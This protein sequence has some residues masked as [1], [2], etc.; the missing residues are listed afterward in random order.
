MMPTASYQ[1]D[2]QPHLDA[3]NH[4]AAADAVMAHVGNYA[5]TRPSENAQGRDSGIGTHWG[6]RRHTQR[7]NGPTITGADTFSG[8]TAGRDIDGDR[9]D[10]MLPVLLRGVVHHDAIDA[11]PPASRAVFDH[12]IEGEVPLRT[13]ANINL[14]SAHVRFP[15]QVPDVEE[16]VPGWKSGSA[17]ADNVVKRR[18]N[19]D[20]KA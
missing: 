3:G 7:G 1:R 18:M 17:P 16:V 15:A 2:V 8:D 4:E 20:V 13:G 6:A 19:R 9:D 11:T 10:M 12:S 14:R 5:E